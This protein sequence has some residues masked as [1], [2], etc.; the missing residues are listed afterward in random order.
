MLL[1]DFLT[2][3]CKESD[4]VE[5]F[6]KISL[7]DLIN[8]VPL[9]SELRST[10]WNHDLN[11]ENYYVTGRYIKK[12]FRDI[13]FGSVFNNNHRNSFLNDHEV[14]LFE[15]ED[16]NY[17]FMVSS[18]IVII[19]HKREFN[20]NGNYFKNK[21]HLT[22]L[23]LENNNKYLKN[24]QSWFKKEYISSYNFFKNKINNKE[25]IFTNLYKDGM[26]YVFYHNF[27]NNVIIF[28][29]MEGMYKN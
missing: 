23:K 17:K 19:N 25:Y 21:I 29:Y 11:T 15:C 18:E 26:E 5:I 6:L 22:K 24:N 13:N 20:N 14:L 2:E 28:N 1:I 7:Y 4:I 3:L 16:L 8:N 9:N 27:L 10:R 12:Y